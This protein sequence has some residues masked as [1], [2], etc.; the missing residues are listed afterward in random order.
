MGN[1]QVLRSAVSNACCRP[2][3]VPIVFVDRLFGDSKLGKDEVVM[4]ARGLIRLLF[5]L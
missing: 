4:Y 3:Q 2:A 5:T 1:Q